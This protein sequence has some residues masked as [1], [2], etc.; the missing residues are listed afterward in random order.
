MRGNRKVVK[1]TFLT[2][3]RKCKI[4]S[5]R[6]IIRNFF[7]KCSDGFFSKWM[8]KSQENSVISKILQNI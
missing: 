8:K 7:S 2:R 6:K 4:N 1:N 3:H 5:N